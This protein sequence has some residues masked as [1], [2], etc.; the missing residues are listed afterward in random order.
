[1]LSDRQSKYSA[2]LDQEISQ[3]NQYLLHIRT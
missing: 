2:L 3:K 1:M